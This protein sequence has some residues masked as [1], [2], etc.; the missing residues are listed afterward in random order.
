MANLDKVLKEEIRRLAARDTRQVSTELRKAIMG[1]KQ[2]LRA[3]ELE[4]KELKSANR[5]FE[6]VAAKAIEKETE[7]LVESADEIRVSSRNIKSLRAKLG[8]SQAEFALLAGVSSQSVYQW[9]KKAGPL[10]LRA[11]VKAQI[12]RLRGMG[13]RDVKAALQQNVMEE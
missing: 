13:R 7:K 5:K 10:K 1:L 3:V 2:R 9:E 4:L 11:N 6:S 12:A 8:L